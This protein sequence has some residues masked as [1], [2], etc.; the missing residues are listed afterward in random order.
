MIESID[1]NM[2]TRDI[3]P[4]LF[5]FSFLHHTFFKER[6]SVSFSDCV[7]I[8]G[9]IYFKEEAGS[10]ILLIFNKKKWKS[11]GYNEKCFIFSYEIMR[12]LLSYHR[13]GE[14]YLN[15]L[16]PALRSNEMMASSQEIAL[17]QVILEQYFPGMPASAMPIIEAFASIESIF[18]EGE[19][20]QIERGRMFE[21]YYDKQLE[22][23]GHNPDEVGQQ[24]DGENSE[25]PDDESREAAQGNELNSDNRD[26]DEHG[27]EGDEGDHGDDSQKGEGKSDD[28][29]TPQGQ[30]A[31]DDSRD[32]PQGQ[33]EQDDSQGTPQDQGE[34]GDSQG[35]PQGQGEQGDSQGTPQGQGE[36]GEA[37]ESGAGDGNAIGGQA[38][39]ARS[40][41][42]DFYAPMNP[43]EPKLTKSG[44]LNSSFL[45][46]DN[47]MAVLNRDSD[48]RPIILG[49]V[50][51]IGISDE[52]LAVVV[53]GNDQSFDMAVPVAYASEPTVNIG[54]NDKGDVYSERSGQQGEL[55]KSSVGKKEG[56]SRSSIGGVKEGKTRGLKKHCAESKTEKSDKALCQPLLDDHPEASVEVSG[57]LENLKQHLEVN[58][59]TFGEEDARPV[60]DKPKTSGGFSLLGA[61]SG[62]Q[63]KQKVQAGRS[64]EDIFKINIR[65]ATIGKKKEMQRDQWHGFNRRYGALMSEATGGLMM[66]VPHDKE[67][68]TPSRHKICVYLDVSGSCKSYSEKMMKLVATLPE[69]KYE[70]DLFV[71]ASYLSPVSIVRHDQGDNT[72][73]YRDVGFGT[74]IGQV[75]KNHDEIKGNNYDAVFVLTD[76]YYSDIE[77]LIGE[78]YRSW[79]F[80]YIPDYKINHPPNARH[81]LISKERLN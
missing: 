43:L 73:D 60:D 66:P 23:S 4:F 33:G 22:A 78:E 71:F 59:H 30:G 38:T 34:Q 10:K 36:Q 24:D 42:R 75:L 18:P 32:T 16:P 15:Q 58:N 65:R 17:T 31:Q 48:A 5:K 77:G 63:V 29:S 2:A 13:R 47:I 61:S 44:M 9:Q 6:V 28:E 81:Y 72:F 27:D 54:Q 12:V 21:Y 11:L 74:S 57:L 41:N 53:A 64:L 19:R 76:G 70:F 50:T 80:F 8:S 69:K 51:D 14:D 49:D 68:D 26:S 3:V 62:G 52:Q 79:S 67:F 37:Q 40:S 1:N 45:Y 7:S 55:I 25:K 39:G 46:S 35:T 56:K 20:E